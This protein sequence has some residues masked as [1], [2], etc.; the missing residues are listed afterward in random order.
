[1]AAQA[2]GYAAGEHE[3]IVSTVRLVDTLAVNLRHLL[4]LM[5]AATSC[6][7]TTHPTASRAV[8]QPGGGMEWVESPMLITQSER[9][10]DRDHMKA[11]N[12]LRTQICFHIAREHVDYRGYIVE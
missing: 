10:F 12:A 6:L 11:W 2:G 4:K 3:G 8:S 7:V 1:M 5:D 9:R